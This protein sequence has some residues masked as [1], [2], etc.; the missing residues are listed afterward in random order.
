MAIGRS[1]HRRVMYRMVITKHTQDVLRERMVL[2]DRV[3]ELVAVYGAGTLVNV[4][5]ATR[6]A[7]V[8]EVRW[9]VGPHHEVRR[10]IRHLV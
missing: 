3:G 9:V 5:G 4:H 6:Y 7:E 8:Q 2:P 1:V 10:T